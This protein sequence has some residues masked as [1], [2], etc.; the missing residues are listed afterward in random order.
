MYTMVEHNAEKESVIIAR[1]MISMATMDNDHGDATIS[2]ATLSAHD[3]LIRPDFNILKIKLYSPGGEVLFSSAP[4]DI[5]VKSTQEYFWNTV[6]RGKTHSELVKKNSPTPEDEIVEVDV[7]ATYVPIMDNGRFQGALEVYLDITDKKEELEELM[8]RIY[9]SV[10]PLVAAAFFVLAFFCLRLQRTLKSQANTEAALA[11]SELRFRELFSRMNSGVAIFHPTNDGHDFEFLDFNSAAE[12]MDK[13]SRADVLA[14]TLTE[15]YPETRE[16]GLLD[17]IRR[18]Q[19][20]GKAEHYPSYRYR[21]EDIESLRDN[22]IYKLSTGE[23]VMIFDDFATRENTGHSLRI[24]V[25]KLRRS[26][27][28]TISAMARMVETR[29]PFTAGHQRRTTDL[30]RRI[31]QEMGLPAEMIEGIRM[32]A[33]IHDLG[34]L[35]VP[36]EILSKPGV[37]SDLEYSLIKVH[38]Q[39]GY[40]ILKEIEFPWPIA[41]IVFQH[42]ERLDGSG[43]PRGLTSKD[44]LLEARVV[45]VADVVEAMA[46]HRPYRPARRIEQVLEEMTRSKGILFDEA[47]VDA[48]IRLFINNNYQFP[49]LDPEVIKPFEIL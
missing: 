3:S 29:D 10:I 37:L 8:T 18:V 35:S 36:A 32:A 5:G 1:H 16:S 33:S 31:G 40:D 28:G 17:V 13:I 44:I 46:S 22:S 24:N 9:F 25:E 21:G 15:I 6:A 26:L 30:A 43:Y 49:T 34:K 27:S 48:C 11:G 2:I 23:V 20:T 12:K 38:P 42:H 45:A 4:G 41:Q 19:K 47:V 39:A 7:V 14:R